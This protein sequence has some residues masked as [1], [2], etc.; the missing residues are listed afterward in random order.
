MVASAACALLGGA[1]FSYAGVGSVVSSFRVGELWYASHY[2][3]VSETSYVY[4]IR[5]WISGGSSDLLLFTPAG[6]FVKS[7][8]IYTTAHGDADHCPRG[9]GYIS[10]VNAYGGPGV[11][12]YDVVTGSL[13][14]SWTPSFWPRSFAYIPG[15]G[16]KYAGDSY[17]VYRF[18]TG[19]SLV[20]S[21]AGFPNHFNLAAT[22]EYAGRPGEYILCAYG[23]GVSVY[24][25]GGTFVGSFTLPSY[26]YDMNMGACYGPGYPSELGTTYWCVQAK[27]GYW[28]WA[29]QLYLGNGIDVAPTS[30]GK[31]KVLYR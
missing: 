5:K 2:N 25:A 30:L 27:W 7:L 13:I 8:T 4:V 22:N 31:I 18:T 24:D 10:A 17:T 9:P 11:H 19:G 26:I 12:D 29:Y 15:G 16:Y 6:D 14:G 20:S 23:L 3:I 1:A 28:A 21:F